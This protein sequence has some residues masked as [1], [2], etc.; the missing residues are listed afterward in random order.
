MPNEIIARK[1][2]VSS[3][4]YVLQAGRGIAALAVVFHHAEIALANK[5]TALPDWLATVFSYGYL[6]VDFFFVLSGFIIYYVNHDR[7]ERPNF[8]RSYALS[9]FLRVFIPYWPVGLAM[10][11]FYLALPQISSGVREWNWFSTITLLPSSAGPALGPAWTLQHEILFYAF[12]LACFMMGRFLI[13]CLIAAATIIAYS[14]FVPGGY[15]ALGLVDLEFGFGI[16]IAWCFV[17]DKCR[18]NAL[19]VGTG[20]AFC[21]LFFVFGTRLTSVIFGL[22]LA[23]LLL[24]AVRA[25]ASGRIGI[26]PMLSLLGAASY[27]VYLVHYPLLSVVS[28]LTVGWNNFAAFALMIAASIIIG[29]IYHKLFELPAIGMVRRWLDGRKK[30][31]V[32]N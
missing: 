5:N 25:E 27:A 7:V 21:A 13:P 24:P 9:R 15:K 10:V 12:A 16:L 20:L 32:A 29:V 18:Q 23:C 30:V 2:P 19:L 3:T 6:G 8:V 11:A 22:G 1:K 31:A 28:R 17:N 26:G 14:W 4:L